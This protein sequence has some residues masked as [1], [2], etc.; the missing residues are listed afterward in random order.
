MMKRI[1]TTEF[2]HDQDSNDT[3]VSGCCPPMPS[4][5]CQDCSEFYAADE[6]ARDMDAAERR[7]FGG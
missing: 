2:D 5:C 6:E 3:P 4:K 7:A 1:T